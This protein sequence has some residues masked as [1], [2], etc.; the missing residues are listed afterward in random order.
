M[1]VSLGPCHCKEEAGE[2]FLLEREMRF[3]SV[4]WGCLQEEFT[5]VVAAAQ[6]T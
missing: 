2:I 3:K 4:Q 6:G 1:L 5:G